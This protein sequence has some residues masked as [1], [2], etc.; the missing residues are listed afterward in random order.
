MKK[1]KEGVVAK[2]GNEDDDVTLTNDQ[3]V[4]STDLQTHMFALG[5]CVCFDETT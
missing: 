4:R 2:R 5:V 1:L 3:V